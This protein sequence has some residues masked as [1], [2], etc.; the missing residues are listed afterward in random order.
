MLDEM[1]PEAVIYL[2]MGRLGNDDFIQKIYDQGIP[3]FT[4]FPLIQSHEEWLDPHKPLGTGILNARIVMPE[5]DGAMSPLC[6]ATT[7]EHPD[8]FWLY[9]PEPERIKAFLEQFT[10]FMNLRTKPNAE[11]KIAIGY[12]KL[13]GKDA[14]LAS[15]MEV[16]PSLYHFLKRLQKEGYNLNGLPEDPTEFKRQLMTFGSVVGDYATAAQERFMNENHPRW[17]DKKTYEQWAS[18][19]LLPEKYQEIIDRY[20]EAPGQ[21][22]S[23]GD[24]LAIAAIEYGNVL[25]FPQPRPAIG[26]DEFDLVHGTEVAPP[27]SYVAPYLYMQKHFDADVLI[28]FG[29]HGNLEFTPGKNVGL[30][31]ADWAEA[32]IGNR[33]H[34]YFYSIDNVGEATI[35]KRR[36]HAVIVSH[37]TP[38]YVKNQLRQ[39]YAPLIERL[40]AAIANPSVNS[41]ALKQEIIRFGLHRDLDLDS[42]HRSP[43]SLE[44]LKRVAAFAE[45]LVQEKI[46]GAYYVMGVPY[47]PSDLNTTLLAITVD[48]LAYTRAQKDRD[49]GRISDRQLHDYSFMTQAYVPAVRRDITAYLH[50]GPFTS[51]MAEVARYRELLLKSP[52]QEF[53]AMLQALSGRPV[54]PSPGGDPVLNPNV[55]PTGRN[56][57][58]INI[59]STPNEKAWQDGI[60]LAE[61]TLENYRQKH[62]SYPHKVSYTFWAGEFI[63]SQGTTLAQA[64]RMLGVEPVRDEQGRVMDLKLTPS[65]ELG[66]PRINIM[67]QVSGQLRDMAESRLKMLTEAVAL[68]SKASD[69]RYPNYVA[70][71]TVTQEQQMVQNG[72]P[73]KQARELSTLRIFGPVNSG[74]S[75]GMLSYTENSGEWDQKSELVDGYINNMCALYGD[76]AHWGT[77][78]PALFKAA[79]HQTDLIVQPRQSN[80]WGPIS[81]DHVYEFTGTLS[82]AATQLNGKEP[83]ALMADY[84]NASLPRL[85][86]VKEAIALETRATLLNPAFVKERMKGEATTAQMFGKMFHNLFGWSVMRASALNDNLYHELYDMYILDK[87]GLNIASYFDSINPVAYQEMTATL[88]ESARKGY[89]K[90]S[91]EQIAVTAQRHADITGRHGAPCTQFVCA[92]PKLRQFIAQALPDREAQAYDRQLQDALSETGTSSVVLKEENLS[93]PGG[94]ETRDR[95]ETSMAVILLIILLGGGLS[96][97]LVSRYNRTRKS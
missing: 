89:W 5:I 27:H 93:G 35:A 6:I 28:H 9:T 37:L 7:N 40:H 46:T 66:R 79:L 1:H 58:S 44:E 11:K 41:T 43:Y 68:A 34:F 32:L 47:T 60:A 84:R 31:Q 64:F 49:K 69:D 67:V 73:P 83:D 22:L 63:S 16:V 42:S 13:S 17:I 18:E 36:S 70:E 30:S 33:P 38:P 80:T 74:Y 94:P 2:P 77:M 56:L 88:L 24:S 23:R 50:G 82:L 3:I 26:H 52:E 19:V 78:D 95:S 25:L 53:N 96:V 45:E 62:G 59:E 55:L 75:T 81:L 91:D 48:K 92:N 71:G 61:Q 21:L 76:T 90:A 72:T 29:T 57:F 54:T 14:L 8:G 97:L 65:A 10:R 15:G 51:E 85:Q 87:H 86:E 20:G 4:P 39:T 12:F